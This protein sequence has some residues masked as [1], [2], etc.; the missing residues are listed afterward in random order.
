MHH[1]DLTHEL[2][3]RLAT[4]PQAL[5]NLRSALSSAG[6]A[7]LQRVEGARFP[8]DS[9]PARR[10]AARFGILLDAETTGLDA[11]RDSVIQLAMRRFLYDE[12]GIIDLDTGFDRF[13]DPGIPIDNSVTAVTGITDADVSG[14]RISDAEVQ[15]FCGPAD[16]VVAHNADFDRRIVE[17]TFPTAGFDRLAW[18][19]SLNEVDWSIRGGGG[20][21]LESLALRAGYV[22]GAHRAANDV[23]ALAFVLASDG[24]GGRKSTPFSELL[25]KAPEIRV[26]A[27][28]SP[29]AAK[30]RLKANGYRWDPTGV[31]TGRSKT[32]WRDIPDTLDAR[33]SEAEFLY[34]IY[35]RS[36]ELP[37]ILQTP[38]TRYS[39]RIGPAQP[40]LQIQP[41]EQTDPTPSGPTSLF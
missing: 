25:A 30:D 31:E 19:C 2:V 39:A 29:F 13:R 6:Y 18:H 32:W 28:G 27:A 41:P 4:D 11:T 26:L 36:L 17:R 1:Q 16:L 38:E 21:S 35:G 24:F 9:D 10:R 8:F 5:E 3:Q 7:L 33:R 15:A 34:G 22:F 37:T 14:Q 12:A 23:L 20:R 40:P